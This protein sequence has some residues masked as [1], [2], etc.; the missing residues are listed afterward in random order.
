MKSTKYTPIV[1]LIIDIVRNYRPLLIDLA[2]TVR[3]LL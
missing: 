1:Y 3:D 2:V